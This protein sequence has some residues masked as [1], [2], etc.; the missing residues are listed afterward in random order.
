[1]TERLT[2]LRGEVWDVA[3]PRGGPHPAVVLTVNIL[4]DRL[5]R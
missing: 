2:P 3:V 1:M 5:P 4:R